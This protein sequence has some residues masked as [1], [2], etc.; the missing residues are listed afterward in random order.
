MFL[1]LKVKDTCHFKNRI[2]QRLGERLL[3]SDYLMGKEF[4][5]WDSEKVADLG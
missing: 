4:S 1:T 5:I 2:S 3:G